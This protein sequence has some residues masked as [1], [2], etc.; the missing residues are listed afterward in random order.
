MKVFAT[1]GSDVSAY[2]DIELDLPVIMKDGRLQIENRESFSQA[3][4]AV[5]EKILNGNISIH[6]EPLWGDAEYGLRLDSLR[7]D[8]DGEPVI[9][10]HEMAFEQNPLFSG[11]LLSSA[12]DA[13]NKHDNLVTEE[14]AKSCAAAFSQA[15]RALQVTPDQERQLIH[16]LAIAHGYAVLS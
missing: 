3:I 9:L 12:V 4:S 13:A 10:E 8:K 16:A 15:L 14:S 1:F 2:G 5:A 6:M 7:I 11:L